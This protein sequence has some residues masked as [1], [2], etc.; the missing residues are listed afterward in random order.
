MLYTYIYQ[1]IGDFPFDRQPVE[2]SIIDHQST[3]TVELGVNC[4]F[5]V[6]FSYFDVYFRV[7]NTKYCE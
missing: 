3:T 5:D 7:K 2:Y 6:C 1:K 4:L